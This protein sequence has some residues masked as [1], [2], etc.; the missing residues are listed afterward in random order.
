VTAVRV[1]F[2]R[3]ITLVGTVV[4]AT[5]PAVT[6]QGRLVGYRTSAVGPI[7]ETWSFSDGVYQPTRN[8]EDSVLVDRVSQVSIPLAVS[9]P[10]GADWTVDLSSAVTHGRV[11]LGAPDESLHTDHYTLSGLTDTRIRATGRLNQTVLLTF[12]LNLPTGKSSLD[13]K[14]FSALRVLA[15]PALG[16]QVPTLAN[17]VSATAGVVLA[18]RLGDWAGA[19]GVSYELRGSYEPGSI[20]ATLSNPDYSPSDALRFSVGLDGLV[21][22]SGMT[23]GLSA[24]FYPTED[25]IED[26]SLQSGTQLV[27]QLGPVLTADWQLRLATPGFRELT[28]YAVDRYRTKYRSG[29]ITQAGSNGNYL[30]MGAR[31]TISAGR[32]TGVVA[33]LN[34]RHQTGLKSDNTIATAA[35]LSAAL[36][37][38]LVHNLGAHYVLQPFVRGQLG[39]LKTG[40]QSTTATGFAGGVT[41][42]LRF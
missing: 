1:P 36:S 15:A 30:D 20:L 2:L 34:V 9:I 7:Y 18:R 17:G 32:A 27:S 25:R 28:L 5:A 6:A 23:I 38:G 10:L 13:A 19:L 12:G 16:L 29:I 14:E 37:L 35:M 22:Q 40:E 33:G 3:I 41:L 26:T 42:G 11:K 21:G 39:R 4:A 8:S 31:T 24:D